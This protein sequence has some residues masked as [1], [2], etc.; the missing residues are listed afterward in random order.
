MSFYLSY[1]PYW[2]KILL[3]KHP[4]IINRKV[5]W[6]NFLGIWILLRLYREKYAK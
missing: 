1:N 2:K 6:C 5:L 3:K 4:L